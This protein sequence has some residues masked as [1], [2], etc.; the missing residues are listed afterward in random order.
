MTSKRISR[1]SFLKAGMGAAG[2]VALAASPVSATR[3]QHNED[4]CTLIDIQKCVACEACV[5][6]CRDVNDV[7]FPEPEGPMP[8]MFPRKKVRVEDWS[9]E[10]KRD[11]TDR[12]TPYNWLF[13]QH[14][15]GTYN[16]KSFELA[17]PRRCM[18]C[19]NPPC[20]NLC[21]FGAAHTLS[22]GIVRIHQDLCMGG[23]KCR[24]VCPWH[25]PQRQ[26]G[27]GLHLDILPQY[28]GN[29]VM[30]KCDRCYD[31][32][33]EGELPACIEVCPEGVQEIGPRK[34]MVE[35]ARRLATQINGFVYGADDNGGTNTIYVSPV[36]FGVLNEAIV[37]G[38]GNPHLKRTADSMADPNRMLA[39]LAIAPVAG[40]IG[41]LGR[42]RKLSRQGE[43]N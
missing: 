41:A 7:K 3:K 25:I 16:G 23:A 31:R 19:L 1:R 8:N 30:F 42:L 11:V 4:L 28:A 9:P 37:I 13:I 22:N 29:G 35:K 10:E 32:V 21:P 5:D 18:H 2:T 39:A 24:A 15:E 12:L 34:E 26:S 38:P 36:P 27:V 17:I 43:G 14:A 33:A 20:V 40:V 6:A